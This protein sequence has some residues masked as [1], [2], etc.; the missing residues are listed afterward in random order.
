[1]DFSLY[2]EDMSKQA[3][4]E[5]TNSGYEEL[6]T[7]EEVDQALTRKGTT[8]VAINSM[9]GCAG[10]V[11]RPAATNSIHFDKRPDHLVTVFAGQDRE[12]TD[13]ARD[14]FE[15]FPPSSPSFALMKDGKIVTMVPREEIESSTPM[16]VVQRLQS[17]FDE[18]CEEY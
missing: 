18:H 7:P 4:E 2:M 8:L 10:G 1:M 5:L 9:C 16:E 13:R 12:A 15:G 6:K 11:A 14:Y 3:R 17:L